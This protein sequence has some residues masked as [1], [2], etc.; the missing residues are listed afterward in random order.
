[1]GKYLEK[2]FSWQYFEPTLFTI[3]GVLLLLLFIVIFLSKKDKTKKEEENKKIET[4]ALTSE[5]TT[6]AFAVVSETPAPLEVVPEE[7]KEEAKEE[8][9]QDS[10]EEKPVMNMD[11]PVEEPVFA[12]V[13]DDINPDFEVFA[14]PAPVAEE[15]SSSTNDNPPVADDVPVVAEEVPTV[16]EETPVVAEE[17]PAVAEEPTEGATE[18]QEDYDTPVVIATPEE[19]KK[20]EISSDEPAVVIEDKAPDKEEYVPVEVTEEKIKDFRNS[21]ADLASSINKELDELDKIQRGES[22]KEAMKKEE[23]KPVLAE[24]DKA[25][26]TPDFSSFESETYNVNE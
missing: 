4:E 16:A 9:K 21:F 8:P 18:K 13:G 3:I 10:V 24:N 14:A 1:M 12:P 23:D 15:A 6:D 7:A 2:A 11:I 25:V 22:S 20:E 5:N 17:I 19:E 26:A